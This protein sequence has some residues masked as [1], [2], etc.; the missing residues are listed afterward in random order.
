MSATDG[1]PAGNGASGAHIGR[2]MRRKEDPRL[3]T[4]Q[5]SYVDDIS[6]QGPAMGGVGALARGARE[7]RLDRRVGGQGPRRR[8]RG[9]HQRGPRH[10]GGPADGLG[11][12]RRA[13]QH[14]GPLGARQGRGQARRRSGRARDRRG[15]L[16][17]DR[18]RR[19]C[20]GRVRPAAGCD[21]P[22]GRARGRPAGARA[23][24]DQQGPATGHWAAATSRRALRRPTS[25]S[26]GASSTIGWPAPRSSR[27]G[28]SPSTA[29]AGSRCGAP[30]RCRIS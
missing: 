13:G 4:G 18:R 3:I 12:A 22:G 5:G 28:C 20:L 24:R 2:A 26:S 14:P 27:A 15:P 16:R 6:L 1:A 29:A 8:R 7:D 9:L 17:R 30:P 23:V 25:S 10:A 21:R 11:P 19:G